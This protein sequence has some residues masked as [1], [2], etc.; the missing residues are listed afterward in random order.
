MQKYLTI[1]VLVFLLVATI[2]L[3]GCG[4][5][6]MNFDFIEKIDGKNL[7]DISLT[8]FYMDFSAFTP[9]PVTLDLLTGGWYDNAG[10]VV[11]GWY[12]YRV[13]VAGDELE[14]FLF[15][16]NQIN[17]DVLIPMRG[18]QPYPPEIRIYYILESKVDGKLFDVAMW[19]RRD[20]VIFN[21]VE[22][23]RNNIFFEVIL[24]FLPE[25]IATDIRRYMAMRQEKQ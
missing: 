12:D 10:E 1:K 7:N 22:V 15:L 24:P 8:I 16:F 23:E 4:R 5:N 20:G 13:V 2:A 21:G 3:A 25:D 18:R 17:N 11:G 14:E 9:I 19:G 6:N